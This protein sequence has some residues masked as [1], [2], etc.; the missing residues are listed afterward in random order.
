[1]SACN[2]DSMLIPNWSTEYLVLRCIYPHRKR[3]GVDVYTNTGR[4]VARNLYTMWGEA[5]LF[6]LC[7]LAQLLTLRD[8]QLCLILSA[9]S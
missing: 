7:Y 2:Y 4:Q 9:P 1:M 5:L 6:A 3:R 8:N